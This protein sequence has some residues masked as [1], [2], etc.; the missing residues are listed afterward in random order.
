MVTKAA[1]KAAG[2][3]NGK[4]ERKEE[5]KDQKTTKAIGKVEKVVRKA[6]LQGK[7][8]VE[9]RLRAPPAEVKEDPKEERVPTHS[10]ENNDQAHSLTDTADDAVDGVTRKQ[11]VTARTTQMENLCNPK[12]PL[13][14][15]MDQDIM[16]L[17][18]RP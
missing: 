3:V 6:I 9:Q 18:T 14:E 12:N 2:M 10:M 16:N 13:E 11:I 15:Q 17:T 4:G 5:R 7:E 1:A 8:P